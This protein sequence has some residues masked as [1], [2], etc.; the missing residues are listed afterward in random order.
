MGKKREV[1]TV[2]DVFRLD[3]YQLIFQ[4]FNELCILALVGNMIFMVF[5]GA[6]PKIDCSRYS[7]VNES[8]AGQNDSEP[9]TS[10]E[11]SSIA[12]QFS[13]VCKD[14][15]WVAHATTAQMVGVLL[16]AFV[17]GHFSDSVG[18]RKTLLISMVLLTLSSVAS[19]FS[20]TIVVFMVFRAVIG[21]FGGAATTVWG[22]YMIEMLP[23]AHRFWLCATVTWSPNYALLSLAAYYT[24]DWHKLSIACGISCLPSI[25]M[26]TFVLHESPHFLLQKGRCKE[27]L[28]VLTA[29]NSWSFSPLKKYEL[30]MLV[31]SEAEKKALHNEDACTPKRYSF[32]HL[33]SSPQLAVHT[34]VISFVF[35]TASMITYSLV[36]NLSLIQGSLYINFALSGILRYL[37]GILIAAVDYFC[38]CAGRKMVHIGSMVITAISFAAVIFITFTGLDED[39]D[40]IKRISTLSAFSITGSI[41]TQIGLMSA[42][43]FPT[44]IRNVALAHAQAF[45]RFGGALSPSIFELTQFSPIVPYVALEAIAVIDIFA[46]LFGIPETKNKPLPDQM[47]TRPKEVKNGQ[48]EESTSPLA[49]ASTQRSHSFVLYKFEAFNRS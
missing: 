28:E 3:L 23:R 6:L 47:P 21:L 32:H 41:F 25:I 8:F 19:A 31:E 38:A 30:S 39:Y 40:Y 24:G 17:G 15:I 33:Y 11:F 26:L 9:I 5:G 4:I 1:H 10:Y 12:V 46:V 20:P 14:K 29:I 49:P 37:T 34:L 43:L 42:E 27:V 44:V 18:R 7:K 45:S 22:V 36:F 48:S 2:D 16:G 35:F 13:L